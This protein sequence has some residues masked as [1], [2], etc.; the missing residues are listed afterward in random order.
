MLKKKKS[1]V[2][3]S[4]SSGIDS[5]SSVLGIEN[6]K[7]IKEHLNEINDLTKKIEKLL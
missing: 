7:S 2:E 5:D 3:D 4:D 6:K 1:L